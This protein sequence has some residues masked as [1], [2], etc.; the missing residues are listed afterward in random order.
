MQTFINFAASNGVLIDSVIHGKIV[1]CPTKEHPAKKNGAYLFNKE[2]GWSQSW[3]IH[4]EPVF[5]NDESIRTP[6]QQ[7]QIDRKIAKSREE[8]A[9]N[10]DKTQQEAARKARWILGEC[11]LTEHKYIQRK[12]FKE[13]PV[14]VWQKDDQQLLI[15]PMYHNNA[16]CGCQ[17][18]SEDGD[19]RF[20]TGQ[21]TSG[22]H[23]KI[24]DGKQIFLVEGFA[25]GLA[26]Q[27]I[28]AS[29]GCQSTIYVTFSVGN[30]TK[31]A[32]YLPNA[33][34]LADHDAN[35]VGQSAAEASGLKWWMPSVENWDIN[36][37][38]LAQG[39]L[40]TG[41]QIKKFLMGVN[42]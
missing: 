26:L 11:E 7:A 16:I 24:G 20:L 36:D 39:K 23:F 37:A 31:M 13:H 27:A 22:A 21:R 28:L 19:K 30:A 29:I 38:Y 4:S 41:M 25:S 32:K 1:R 40:K 9:R 2:W 12:G 18:I 6:E 15:V 8:Y 42:K 3:E 34:W 10:R 14:N 17:I 5:W 35:G 33:Y